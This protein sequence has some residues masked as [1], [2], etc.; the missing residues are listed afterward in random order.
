[1]TAPARHGRGRGLAGAW[2]ALRGERRP[3]VE[4]A[5]YPPPLHGHGLELRPWDADLVAQMATWSAR[6]FPYHAFDLAFLRDPQRAAATLASKREAGPHRHFVAIENGVAVG[7]ASVN[8]RDDAGLYL[9]A[10]HVPPEHEGRG[11][12]RRMLLVL[13][14]WL[15]GEHP[16]RDFILTTNTFA[17]PAHRA[18]RAIGFEVSESRWH[19]DR[20]VAEELWKASPEVREQIAAHVRFA[21]GRWETRAYVMRRKNARRAT[22]PA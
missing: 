18:Y 16:T 11:I 4:L 21:N 8:L 19:Y 1:M 12:C 7:R 17:T 9:W 10:V 15:E 22:T 13:M 20:E 3:P 6:G 5:H 14:A 2:Q